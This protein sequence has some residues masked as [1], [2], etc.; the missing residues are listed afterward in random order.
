MGNTIIRTSH[1][2]IS[3][4]QVNAY[5]GTPTDDDIEIAKRAAIRTRQR[6]AEERKKEREKS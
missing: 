3:Y 6:W 5:Y 1:V 4:R 2:G